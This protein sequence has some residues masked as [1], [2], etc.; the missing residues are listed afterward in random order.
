[1][2]KVL[3]IAFYFNQTNEIASKRLRGLAKYLTNFDWEPIVI[4]PK[5]DNF[6]SINHEFNVIETHYEDMLDKWLN[7]FKLNSSFNSNND[8]NITTPTVDNININSTVDNSDFNSTVDNSDFNSTV[9]NSDFN[10]TVDNSDFNSTVDNSDF[11]STIDNNNFNSITS[12]NKLSSKIISMMGEVFAYPDGMKYWYK[13]A[14]EASQN[15]I[16][17]NDIDAIISSSWPITSHII[18]KNIK[19]QYN[20]PWIADLRD[21]WNMNPYVHHTFIR[22][23]FER[24]LEIKTFKYADALTTTTERAALKLKSLHKDK[25]VYPIL[26]GFDPEDILKN[27]DY[28]FDILNIKNINKYDSKN[29]NENN[30]YNSI[31]NSIN[32]NIKNNQDN[33]DLTNDTNDINNS[34]VISVDSAINDISGNFRVDNLTNATNATDVVDVDKTVFTDIKN[35]IGIN[36]NIS[37]STTDFNNTLDDFR[38][39]TEG[40]ANNT[41]FSNIRDNS[42]VSDDG[43]VRDSSLNDN[44]NFDSINDNNHNIDNADS[45]L[46]FIYAGSLYN[47]KRNPEVLFK[48]IS[49]LINEKK[50]DASKIA[51]NFYGDSEGLEKTAKI[52]HVRDIVTIHGSIHHNEVLKKQIKSQVLLLLSWNNENEKMFLPGKVYEYLAVKRPVL[53]I[54][55]K[56]GSLKDLIEK[57][58]VGVHVS[59]LS[60][61]KS[62]IMNFYNDFIKNG[63]VTYN[64]ND[65]VNQYSMMNTAKEFGKLLDSLL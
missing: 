29:I 41:T 51:L 35:N 6:P 15:I 65:E 61:T 48:A 3:L 44:D 33:F 63:K 8:F 60:E 5:L 14:I 13:P 25:N 27:N 28:N 34:N 20:I 17:N 21:L 36:D 39:N 58:N 54:G 4:V 43:I 64:G 52:Y 9:D 18:A 45:I 55:Y 12:T 19:K 31:Y 38:L 59:T 30:N 11:N 57:T 24:R 23:F 56:E 1:M 40:T 42:V 10:S 62:A 26:S 2:K 47:G 53:S 7:K 16:E 46:D 49:E 37:T 50:I 32:S 22:S